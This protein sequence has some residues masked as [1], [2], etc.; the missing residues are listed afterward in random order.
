MEFDYIE[1]GPLTPLNLLLSEGW[2][3]GGK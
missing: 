3:K 1:L 2:A